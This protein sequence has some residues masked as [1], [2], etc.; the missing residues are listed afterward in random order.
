M[1][2]TDLQDVIETDDSL[3]IL[4]KEKISNFVIEIIAKMNVIK[5]NDDVFEIFI[6][7][8]D[9]EEFFID[10]IKDVDIMCNVIFSIPSVKAYLAT[11]THTIEEDDEVEV[12]EEDEEEDEEV[13]VEV[14]EE[15]DD[16][17]FI[18][19][20]YDVKRTRMNTFII[21]SLHVI[22]TIVIANIM[23]TIISIGFTLAK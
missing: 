5:I 9:I 11:K 7:M 12:E 2:I 8:N 4:S 3:S 14:E 1:K 15:D 19:V 13:E 18:E 23:L 21:E 22:K 17:T 20:N 10:V 16:A 6:H